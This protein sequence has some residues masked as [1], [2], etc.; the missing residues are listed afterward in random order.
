M[1]NKFIRFDWSRSRICWGLAL[2]LQFHIQSISC[3]TAIW[4]QRGSLTF[5]VP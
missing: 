4:T 5:M 2:S 1:N 3:V